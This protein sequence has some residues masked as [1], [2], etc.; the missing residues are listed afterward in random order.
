MPEKP[1]TVLIVDDEPAVRQTFRA[2]LSV[3]GHHIIA[4][5]SGEEALS[6]M[7]EVSPDVILLD[8]MMPGMDGFEVCR[9]IRA[10]K[11]W[12]HIPI[13]IV[14][15]LD[16]REDIIHGIDAGAD[17]FLSKP[18]GGAELRARVRS[19]LR[20]KFMFDDLNE[21][22]EMREALTN[23]IVHDMNSP[24]SVI[25][26]TCTLLKMQGVDPEACN[27][28]LEQILTQS[29]RLESFLNDML[30]LAKAEH[31]KL[32]LNL[33]DV[34]IIELALEAEKDHRPIAAS[35]NINLKLSLPDERRP[36]GLDANLFRRV[37]DNLLSN[38][39]KYSP[40]NTTVTLKVEYPPEA[41]AVG[42]NKPRVR[43][44]VIDEGP[45]IPEDHRE[46]IFSEFSIIDLRRRGLRQIGLGLALCRLAVEEHGGRIYVTS[47]QPKGSVFT[48]EV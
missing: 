15:A 19:M 1:G 18:V 46:D 11:R 9:R 13:I 12:R 3:E 35:K 4:A 14:T 45:G 8:V 31:D 23:L 38:A 17:E 37:I 7:D 32:I 42:K 10:D 26:M 29:R 44:K 25:L 43:L 24:L 20:I 6:I 27:S 39:L 41:E 34:D 28:A 5:E 16:S 36:I 22:L 40:P 30:L 33:S 48:V 2:L 47:N 21:S